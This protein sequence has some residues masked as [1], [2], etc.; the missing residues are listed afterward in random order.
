MYNIEVTDTFQGEANYCWVKRGTTKATSRRGLIKAIKDVA[1]W[2]DWCRVKVVHHDGDS[3][4][5]RPTDTSGVCQVAFAHWV[6]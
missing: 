4:E 3:I 1:G 6:D 5:V 2:T